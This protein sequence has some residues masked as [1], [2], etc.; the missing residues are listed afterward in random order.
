MNSIFGGSFLSFLVLSISPTL[1]RATNNFQYSKTVTAEQSK[2][3]DFD[4]NQDWTLPEDP[5]FAKILGTPDLSNE[6]IQKFLSDRVHY[7]VGEEEDIKDNLGVIQTAFVYENPS[8]LPTFEVPAF[9]PDRPETNINPVPPPIRGQKIIMNNIGLS[10][11]V[12]GKQNTELVGYHF[13]SETEDLIIPI[14]SPLAGILKI[15]TGLFSIKMQ[16]SNVNAQSNSI[17]RMANLM[18]EAHHDDGNGKFL[19][20]PHAV[21]PLGH[22]YYNRNACDRN[23]NG[24]YSV[25]AHFVRQAQIKCVANKTCTAAEAEQ[26]AIVAMDFRNRVIDNEVYDSHPEEN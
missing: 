22:D 6:S 7:I 26:L 1:A 19:G 25:A 16:N 13:T 18:H 9:V 14:K 24:P 11:Y 20:F 23:A 4:I 12:L 3:L 10:F 21:C 5:E 2:I 8:V 15:G 17:F